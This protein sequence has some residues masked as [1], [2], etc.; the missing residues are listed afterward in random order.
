MT[1]IKKDYKIEDII[2]LVKIYNND[3][4]DLI[5]KS[6]EYT[7][8]ILDPDKLQDSLNVSYLLTTVQADAETI[9]ANIL[10]YLL[11]NDLVKRNILEKDF[12]FRPQTDIEK[13]LYEFAK[14]YKGY[15]G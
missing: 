3:N 8:K 10:S 14:W 1:K 9:S 5:N 13:G 15:R 12:D 11:I 6:Y 7:S 2:E 4:I